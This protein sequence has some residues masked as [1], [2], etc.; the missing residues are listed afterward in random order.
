MPLYLE[1]FYDHW[2]CK[3]EAIRERELEA[4]VDAYSRP[5]AVKASIAYYRARAAARQA[6]AADAPR[7]SQ[8]LQPAVIAWGELDPVILSAWADR[9]HDTFPDH[10]LSLLPGIGHFVPIEAPEET[11]ETIRRALRRAEGPEPVGETE[12]T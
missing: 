12:R 11:I 5:G 3:K 2:C 10:E 8:I 1:Y 6:Q 7:E 9:L 4:I